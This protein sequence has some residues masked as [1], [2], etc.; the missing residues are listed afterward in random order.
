M[1]NTEEAPQY[2]RETNPTYILLAA[3]QQVE[4]LT[5]LLEGNEWQEYIY[6]HL[7]PIKFELERQYER[8][9]NSL[10]YNSKAQNSS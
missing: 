10:N 7:I 5:T 9:R 6:G 4:N 2:K 1:E 3:L 8:H